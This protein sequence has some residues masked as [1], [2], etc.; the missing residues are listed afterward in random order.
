MITG[1]KT[2]Q[3]FRKYLRWNEEENADMLMKY[4]MKDAEET[5]K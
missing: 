5:K 1:H 2:E 3:N 4:F